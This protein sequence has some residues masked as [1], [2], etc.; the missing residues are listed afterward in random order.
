MFHLTNR[1]THKL[2]RTSS[3][4]KK[5]P[6]RR[7]LNFSSRVGS[8][9]PKNSLLIS[10]CETD[11]KH[12]QE[13]TNTHLIIPWSKIFQN[14]VKTKVDWGEWF[15]F[16]FWFPLVRQTNK[17]LIQ[18]TVLAG[19]AQN[20]KEGGSSMVKKKVQGWLPK[21]P[22]RASGDHLLRKFSK[23]T[24]SEMGYL[25][26]WGQVRVLHYRTFSVTEAPEPSAEHPRK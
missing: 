6:F 19:C 15:Q 7:A 22:A 23:S 16:L 20:F 25:A 1:G 9:V 3:P 12:I 11:K 8:A 24:S 2:Y 14:N 10:S 21:N 5:G 18:G 4:K 17:Q 26:L 13:T